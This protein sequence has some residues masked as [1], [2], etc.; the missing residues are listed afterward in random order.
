[1]R[2]CGLKSS[3]FV[4]THTRVK[5]AIQ[6][7]YSEQIPDFN[8]RAREARDLIE[9]ISIARNF[10]FQSTRT[11]RAYVN[12]NDPPWFQPAIRSS[13]SLVRRY[14]NPLAFGKPM[15]F[16]STS[17]IAACAKVSIHVRTKRE[18]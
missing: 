18:I 14:F 1:M 2:A 13:E 8:P 4:S 15:P 10:Q 7:A 17:G 3:A 11:R 5:R 12:P 9:D 6:T 16:Q